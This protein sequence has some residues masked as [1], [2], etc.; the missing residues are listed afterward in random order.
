MLRLCFCGLNY[1][2]CN[3]HSPY[4]IVI[5]NLFGC[6]I[7]FLDTIFGEK[8]LPNV[9]FVVWLPL[10]LLSKKFVILR[11]S[12]WDIVNV[13][14]AS[15]HAKDVSIIVIFHLTWNF[16]TDFAKNTEISNLMKIRP[17]GDEL[18][19][20]GRRAARPTGEQTWRRQQSIFEILGK[21]LQTRETLFWVF[22]KIFWLRE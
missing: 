12:D 19:H 21:P 1:P 3:S 2:A 7:F 6:A 9:K 17:V 11:R 8:K 14:I 18:S 15:L 20:N 16:W 13:H 10:Q 4:Y 5:S 22:V